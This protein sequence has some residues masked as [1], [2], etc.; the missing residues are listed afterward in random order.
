MQEHTREDNYAATLAARTF[1][2]LMAIAAAYDLEAYQY[3]VVSAFT[4][5]QLNET[6]YIECLDSFREKNTCLLLYRA[7]YGLR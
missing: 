4:N 3:D 7:L 2:A 5:S 6:I 1:R